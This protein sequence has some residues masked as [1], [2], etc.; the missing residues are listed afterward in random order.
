MIAEVWDYRVKGVQ[1]LVYMYPGYGYI[2]THM[3]PG[4]LPP[5]FVKDRSYG[6]LKEMKRVLDEMHKEIRK[7]DEEG[8]LK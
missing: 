8:E 7:Y 2:K 6:S 5:G 1:F 3:L 4:S